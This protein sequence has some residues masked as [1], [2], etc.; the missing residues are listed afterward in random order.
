MGFN[1]FFGYIHDSLRSFFPGSFILK[2]SVILSAFFLIFL[3]TAIIFKKKKTISTKLSV[4]LNLVLCIFI[5]I[6]IVTVV[7]KG[8]FSYTQ[9]KNLV[10]KSISICKES[11]HP[12]VYLIVADEYAGSKDLTD[13]CGF[14]N[15]PF[16][17]S[18]RQKGFFVANNSRSNY[19]FTSYSMASLLNMD[20]LELKKARI[21]K[22]DHLY[23]L[24]SIFSN[25]VTSIFKEAGYEFHNYSLFDISGQVAHDRN[26][27]VPARTELF[28]S[29]TLL[30]RLKKDVWTNLAG[31]LNLKDVVKKS[32]L[33]N[34]G[35][36]E[37]IF[38]HTINTAHSPNTVPKF[39]YTHLE[40]PHYP[41]YHD[42]NGNPYP[43]EKIL[44][45]VPGNK[46]NYVEYL[47]YTNKVLLK[48]VDEIIQSN[49]T[50]PVV[51]LMSDHG[52]RCYPTGAEAY[53]FVNL[54]SV[55]LP[56][57][58]YRGFND[59]ITNVNVFRTLLNTEFCQQLPI[60][61]DTSITIGY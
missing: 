25:K 37:Q 34:L 12:D 20:Y 18:L 29:Q 28:T 55:Y 50:P 8:L 57:K 22:V 19:N 1:F 52:Y 13:I 51:I 54:F 42:R 59:S 11:S 41:Y 45:D 24:K 6:D 47:Q 53:V 44:N 43:Y 4:Y 16:L 15:S 31:M 5:L 40:L 46:K 61:K 9:E 2:Y 38:Q 27:F 14:D 17:D 30:K 60:L 36:N 26:S 58:D 10:A 32:L 49:R 21:K 7:K 56:N 48:L 33:E 3:I 23:A 35:Y 39:V